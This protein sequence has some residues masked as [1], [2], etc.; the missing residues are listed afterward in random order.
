MTY[1]H[2]SLRPRKR[3]GRR[4]P[5]GVEV[6][7]A[8]S[9]VVGK[10]APAA[11]RG[12]GLRQTRL[13]PINRE[14]LARTHERQYGSP[15]RR[16][17]VASLPC[18]TCGRRP[19]EAVPNH[20]SHVTRSR[21]AGG[22]P[23]DVIAQCLSCHLALASEGIATFCARRNSTRADLYALADKTAAAWREVEAGRVEGPP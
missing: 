7:G 16:A 17:W 1:R 12:A 10:P 23:G 5:L 2:P 8:R 6:R 11:T 20:N 18:A 3:F 9:R 13:N 15:E 4:T 14:R 22:G 19:T 21:G